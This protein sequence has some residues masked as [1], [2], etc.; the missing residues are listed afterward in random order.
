MCNVT[1]PK[2]PK[3]SRDDARKIVNKSIN[4]AKKLNKA[5]RN[6]SWKDSYSVDIVSS[7]K[8]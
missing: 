5:I 3:L 6:G 7:E 2:N 8:K 4:E 1:M